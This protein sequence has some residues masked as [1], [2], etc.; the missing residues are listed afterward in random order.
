[1]IPW[2]QNTDDKKA[3]KVYLKKSINFIIKY[4]NSYNLIF[5]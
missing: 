3:L 1:M 4:N 5:H 2:L